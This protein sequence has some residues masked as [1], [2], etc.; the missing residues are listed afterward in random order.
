MIISNYIGTIDASVK[1]N[2]NNTISLKV[3][4][5]CD[6]DKLKQYNKIQ[7]TLSSIDDEIARNCGLDEI[8]RKLVTMILYR[9]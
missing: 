3:S 9:E 7:E 4:S 6:I 2:A 1:F 5:L 8:N